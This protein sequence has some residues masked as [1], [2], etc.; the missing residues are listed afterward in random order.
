[1]GKIFKWLMRHHFNHPVPKFVINS[2]IDI[3]IIL[4]RLDI[5]LLNV[6]DLATAF[7]LLKSMNFQFE[8]ELRVLF[9][10]SLYIAKF[11]I[12]LY[13]FSNCYLFYLSLVLL[14]ILIAI[15]GGVTEL[16]I[17]HI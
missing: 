4:V 12:Q 17:T 6:I 8:P 5:V 13:K 3:F 10:L 1:M 2:K 14:R 15:G 16:Q 7:L 9:V 11:G